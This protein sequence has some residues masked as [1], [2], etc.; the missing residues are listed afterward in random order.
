MACVAALAVFFETIPF[1][2]GGLGNVLYFFFWTVALSLPIVS[3]SVSLDW[4]GVVVL[5]QSMREALHRLD[6]AFTEGFNITWKSLEPGELKTFVWTG[7]DWTAEI[8]LSR[9]LWIAG[10]LGLVCLGGL[11]FHRFDSSRQR[12][13]NP[14][15]KG[16]RRGVRAGAGAEAFSDDASWPDSDAI[17]TAKTGNTVFGR[18]RTTLPALNSQP[19]FRAFV[20]PALLRVAVA[21]MRLMVR[22]QRWWWYLGA[23]GLVI[24]GLVSS[25]ESARRYLLPASWLWPV[26]L[27]SMLGTRE[28]RFGTSQMLLSSPRPVVRQTPAAW[29]AGALLMILTGSGVGLN[30]LGS[31]MWP[32]FGAW[33]A[34]VVFVPS[35]ALALGVWS[36][37]NRLFE[38]VYL[39]LWYLGPVHPL[40]MP[41]LDF[42]GAADASILSGAPIVFATLGVVLLLLAMAGRWVRS[43]T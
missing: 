25:P 42:M 6:P 36:Q 4:S 14:K 11:R 18:I 3:M 10:S 22:G 28:E 20:R 40:E 41:G 7:V 26:L 2:R 12:Y 32:A 27:L 15:V 31:G 1:L 39:L 43:R 21:E 5:Y 13:R 35:L 38:I 17:G 23:A 9:F 24:A 30:L 34:G 8:V 37:T 33:C 16:R 29:M 19:L